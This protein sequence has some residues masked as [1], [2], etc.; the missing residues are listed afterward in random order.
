MCEGGNHKTILCGEK[1]GFYGKQHTS[2]NIKIM[3]QKKHGGNNPN[4]K[5]I[6]CITTGE[7]FPS[8]R[9]A[10]DWCGIARQNISRCARGERPTAGKHPITKEKLKWSYVEYEI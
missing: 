8:C 1:N 5:K 4:A 3:K 2:E 6:K 7:V 9:E 10:S